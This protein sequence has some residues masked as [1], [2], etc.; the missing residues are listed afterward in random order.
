L[1]R[2]WFLSEHALALPRTQP[3]MW[4]NRAGVTPRG[5]RNLDVIGGLVLFAFAVGWVWSIASARA[6]G[7]TATSDTEITP[8]TSVVASAL[9]HADAPSAAYLTDAALT[10]LV[11][12]IF[13]KERGASGKLRAA[14]T[15]APTPLTPDTL[16]PGAQVEYSQGGEI[17]LAPRGSGVWNVLLAIGNAVRPVANFNVIAMLPFS[18]KQNG[19]VGLYYLGTWPSEK[20]TVGS[21]KAPARSYANPAGFIEVTPQNADTPVSEH[22]KLRDFLT[23]DQPNV[24]PKY[25]VLQPRLIDKLE[26]VLSDLQSHGIDIQGV[27]VMSGF[28]TPQYNYTGGNTGGRANLSR[29]MYGD[30]SDIYIDDNG[31][32]QM[33]DLNHDGKVNIDDARVILEAVDRVDMAHPELIG[34]AGVYTAAPGHGPFIHIDTRGYRARWSG[35]SGG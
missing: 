17:A 9:T 5:E 7:A 21:S 20:G 3:Q 10:A 28:R 34:G 6:L 26:L 8:V 2:D 11:N 22:F 19:R 29:H 33:D 1:Q 15:A 16:P 31:D 13:D 30:A 27:R 4:W 23:H 32:G 14:I 24:W 18:A 25:L 12:H 35:T